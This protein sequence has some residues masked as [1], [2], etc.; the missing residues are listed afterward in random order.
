MNRRTAFLI[1][2]PPGESL[3]AVAENWNNAGGGC[4]PAVGVGCVGLPNGMVIPGVTAPKFRLGVRLND[5][6]GADVGAGEGFRGL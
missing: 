1:W 5:E 6:F 3:G 4:D 2:R